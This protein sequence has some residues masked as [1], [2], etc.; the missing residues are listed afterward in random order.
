[1]QEEELLSMV[2]EA[3]FRYYW[4]VGHPNA[5]LAPEVFP[6]DPNL[7]AISLAD[8]KVFVSVVALAL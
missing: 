1:M 7:A 6:G 2:Q 5:G 3:C 4:D 8:P